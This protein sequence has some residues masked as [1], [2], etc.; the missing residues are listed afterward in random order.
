MPVSAIPEH[1]RCRFVAALD[2][3][4]GMRTVPGLFEGAVT[5]MAEGYGRMAEKFPRP[6]SPIRVSRKVVRQFRNRSS[7]V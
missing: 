6:P 3:V 4:D 7:R 5:G 2:K 1:R